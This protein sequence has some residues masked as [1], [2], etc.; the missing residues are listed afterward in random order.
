MEAVV[1]NGVVEGSYLEDRLVSVKPIESSGKWGTLLVK[2]EEKRKDAFLYDKIKR[3]FQ[4][5]LRN[6]RDGG[7]VPQILD[8]QRRRLVV[9]Y[10]N[11]FPNGMTQKEFFE[12]ELGINLNNTL[13]KEENFWRIDKRGR[14]T[15]TKEGLKLNLN[16][17]LDMLRYLILMSN[18]SLISPSYEERG[19]KLSYEFTMVDESKVTSKKIEEANVKSKAYIKYAEITSNRA[20]TIGFIKS[21]GRTIPAV[22]TEDW[23][24]NEVLNALEANPAAFLEIVNHPQYNARIFVQEAVEA[25]AIIKRHD[26]RYVL[27]NGAELGDLSD[28]ITFLGNPENQELKLRIKAK[29][30]LKNKN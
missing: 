2:G 14:V 16:N 23:L 7:G 10:K 4:V 5:P 22:H 26:K 24:Q 21:L 20:K 30:E 18:K 15:I 27:D 17:T 12:K 13:P 11:E 19:N 28:T 8:D 6:V 29:I 9:K 1:A 3:S 25:G